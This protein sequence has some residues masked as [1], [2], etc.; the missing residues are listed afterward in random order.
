MT[1]TSLL[2]SSSATLPMVC[3]ISGLVPRAK[4]QA[5]QPAAQLAEVAVGIR[6]FR[7]IGQIAGGDRRLDVRDRQFGV[8][9]PGELGCLRHRELR[10]GSGVGSHKDLRGRPGPPFWKDASKV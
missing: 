2:A 6:P 4:L 8:V 5:G 3:G 9:R 10:R 7:G 1:T